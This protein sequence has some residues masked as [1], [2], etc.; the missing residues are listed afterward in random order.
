MKIRIWPIIFF[1]TAAA[2]LVVAGYYAY[3]HWV[4]P[5]PTMNVEAPTSG[6]SGQGGAARSGGARALPVSISIASYDVISDGSL[7]LGS[8]FP[9]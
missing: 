7:S 4:S 8:L 1:C 3:T 5:P 6:G 2:I 9:N